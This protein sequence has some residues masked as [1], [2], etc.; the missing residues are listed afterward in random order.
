MREKEGKGKNGKGTEQQSSNE[1]FVAQLIELLRGGGIH[2]NVKHPAS[3]P[4]MLSCTLRP[5]S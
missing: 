1:C 5:A 2:L 4:R 3:P